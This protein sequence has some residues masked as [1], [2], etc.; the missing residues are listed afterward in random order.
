MIGLAKLAAGEGH[1]EL[2]ERPERAPGAGEVAL[3][4][5]A[6]GVCGTDLHIWLGE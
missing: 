2:A 5:A 4:V 3:D 1:V 6:V